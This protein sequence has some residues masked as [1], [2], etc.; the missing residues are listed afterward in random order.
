MLS[1]K[2]KGLNKDLSRLV[3]GCDNQSNIDHAF[4]MFDHFFSFGGNVF[5][6]A[7]IY[8]K[9]K[10]EEYLGA[11]INDRGI[12]DKVAI[13]GKGAH[14]P[15]C[16]P[17]SVRKQL[18]VSLERLKADSLDIYCLHRDNPDI[19]VEEFVDSLDELKNEGLIEIKGVSNWTLE[20]FVKAQEYSLN[21]GKEGF[22][23]LSNNFS[24]A[25]MNQPV[26]PGCH[27]CSDQLFKEYILK[28]QVPVFPWSSQARGFFLESKNFRNP[29]HFSDPTKEERDR[30]WKS[31]ENNERRTRCLSLAESK[32]VEPIQIALAFV[33]NQD[34][35]CFPL[36]GS[37][38]ILETESS[39]NACNI[40]LSKIELAWLDLVKDK[41]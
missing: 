29:L 20:R 16:D 39:I 24:L 31:A 8:N 30:V 28:N 3:L 32:G 14:T 5:D 26:W 41:L 23:A 19:P 36:I 18:E 27:S 37:R 1:A 21:K 38:K 6:T 15:H 9:G 22:G 4:A 10:S 35:P 13:L 17:E 25:R 12:R 7:F 11:W 40:S 2:L 33:L 34:F